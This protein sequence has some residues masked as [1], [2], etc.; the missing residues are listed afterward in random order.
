MINNNHI[1]K[2]IANAFFLMSFALSAHHCLNDGCQDEA[3]ITQT[4]IPRSMPNPTPPY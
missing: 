1:N 2:F 3:T 4:S